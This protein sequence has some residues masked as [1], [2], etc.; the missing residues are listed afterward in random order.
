MFLLLT[1]VV[2]FSVIILFIFN[3]HCKI[4]LTK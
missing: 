3:T 1:L 2:K 4:Q